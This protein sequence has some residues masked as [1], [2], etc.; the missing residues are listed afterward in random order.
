VWFL[1]AL[2][3]GC[4]ASPSGQTGGP[5]AR[6][7]ERYGEKTIAILQGA[8]RVEVFRLA[9]RDYQAPEK[10]KPEE[11]DQRFGGYKV[12][13]RGE[14]Q[15]EDFATRAAT[16]LLDGRNFELDRAKACKF[17][18]GVGLR[19]WKG[20]EAAELLLCYSFSSLQ[21]VAPDPRAQGVQIPMA[22]FGPGREAFVKLAREA[23]PKDEEIRKLK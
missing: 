13:A 14:D 2:T 17:D 12:T 21:V 10:A 15:G 7:R 6:L 22:D 11:A 4:S 3:A 5:P 20:D 18:P 9:P 8:K 19:F 23:L 16:A 1:A